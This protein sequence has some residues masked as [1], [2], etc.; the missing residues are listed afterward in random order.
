[1]AW[2][3]SATGRPDPTGT[4]RKRQPHS[5]AASES[6]RAQRGVTVLDSM[7]IAP[8]LMF[9]SAFHAEPDFARGGVVR[10]YSDHHIGVLRRLAWRVADPGT[11]RQIALGLRARS[12]PHELLLSHSDSIH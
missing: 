12:V 7:Q 3:A 6:S 5:F 8:G 2:P 9:D 10:D 1:M 4:S 11:L